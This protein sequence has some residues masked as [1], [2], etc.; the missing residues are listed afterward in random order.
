MTTRHEHDNPPDGDDYY[1]RSRSIDN[2]W[3][4][5]SAFLFEKYRVLVWAIGGLLLAFGFGFQ[6]PSAKFD[7]LTTE[8]HAGDTKLQAQVDTINRDR[9]SQRQM[10]E[11]SVRYICAQLTDADRYRLGGT[12][13]CASAAHSTYR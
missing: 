2:S 12:D 13:I 1:V 11:F 7:Q 3:W 8:L 9:L 6:T 5:R 4:I 10:M